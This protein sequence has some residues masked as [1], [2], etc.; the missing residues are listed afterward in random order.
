MQEVPISNPPVVT[1]ICDLNK[2]WTP[3][4]RS[5]KLGSKVKYLNI[6]FCSLNLVQVFWL[7]QLKYCTYL[8]FVC[9]NQIGCLHQVFCDTAIS[10]Q[11]WNCDGLMVEINCSAQ[12]WFCPSASGNCIACK[13]FTFQT[14][15]WSLEFVIR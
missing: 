7:Y 12:E 13:R 5:L 11:F 8:L 4:H 3:Q 6:Y 15:L 10:S 2:S 1:K 9:N 14:L